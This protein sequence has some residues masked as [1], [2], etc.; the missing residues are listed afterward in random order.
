MF[1]LVIVS[2]L[3]Y[4]FESHKTNLSEKGDVYM[5]MVIESSAF[6]EGQMIPAKYTCDGQNISPP[7]N[8]KNAPEGTRSF[9]IIC[10]DPDASAGVWVHWVVWNIP[11]NVNDLS[12]GELPKEAK[13]G[14]NDFRQRGYGGPC[15]P[16]GT[17]HYYFKLYA[18][19]TMLELSGN[20]TKD[21]LLDAMEKRILTQCSLM[22]KYQH[23]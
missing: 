8:W 20:V 15:P 5:T 6:Q 18:L 1:V 11:A 23:K 12:A 22:G 14:I 4:G 10:D 2:V 21:K 17:H 3:V 7:L 9:A 16:S 19:N 13:Q